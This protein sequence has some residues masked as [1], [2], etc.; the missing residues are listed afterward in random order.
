[1]Q[2]GSFTYLGHPLAHP[3]AKQ[4]S[5]DLLTQSFKQ[6]TAM[7]DRL[8]L[9]CF[10]RVTIVNKV[11]LPRWVYR[12][13]FLLDLTTC[14][15]WDSY[16]RQFVTACPGIESVM[17]RNRLGTD[18]RLGGLGLRT[19]WWSFALRWVS[20]VQPMLQDHRIP[21][22]LPLPHPHLTYLQILSALGVKPG[23][24]T[25]PT[26]KPRH[27]T[28]LIDSESSG[29]EAWILRLPPTSSH[30]S[31][32]WFSEPAHPTKQEQVSVQTLLP[33]KMTIMGVEVQYAGVPTECTWYTD[34]S[35]SCG[36]AGGG[37]V[38]GSFQAAFRVPGMQEVYRAEVVA[39]A[40][41]CALAKVADTIKLDNRACATCIA[42]QRTREVPD[43]DFRDL[44]CQE[45]SQKNLTILWTPGHVSLNDTQTYTA[46]KDARENGRADSCARLGT[47][48]PHNPPLLCNPWDIILHGTKL[49]TPPRAWLMKMRSQKV[50]TNTHW[51]TWLPL[52]GMRRSTWLPWLWGHVRWQDYGAPWEKQASPCNLCTLN[53]GA[54]VQSRL[55]YCGRWRRHFYDEWVKWWGPL[56]A[57]ATVWLTSADE[58]DLWMCACLHIP[59]TLLES[60]PIHEKRH[61]RKHVAFFQF[62]AIHGVQ[63]LRNILTGVSPVAQPSSLWLSTK[64]AARPAVPSSSTP[65]ARQLRDYVHA[66]WGIKPRRKEPTVLPTT[67]VQAE[68]TA[69]IEQAT[70]AKDTDGV[71]FI[72]NRTTTVSYLRSKAQSSYNE[73]SQAHYDIM[74]AFCQEKTSLWEA[75]QHSICLRSKLTSLQLVLR[76][77]LHHLYTA[78]H[79]WFNQAMCTLLLS[80]DQVR[81]SMGTFW[82][83]RQQDTSRFCEWKHGECDAQMRRLQRQ[84][85]ALSLRQSIWDSLLRFTTECETVATGMKQ[86]LL[87]ATMERLSVRQKMWVAWRKRLR[88]TQDE[89]VTSQPRHKKPKLSHSEP[90]TAICLTHP[91]SIA[92]DQGTIWLCGEGSW[93]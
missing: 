3:S 34:G 72:L 6:D 93:E 52:K 61:I 26:R 69:W 66:P 15:T 67:T 22:I 20:I 36:R 41:A 51:T 86:N 46:Y 81:S 68:I 90:E 91:D 40:L 17:S 37:I 31:F 70:A 89:E 48:L 1:M 19:L 9:N 60:I 14:Q 54:S 13:L 47:L 73:L 76:E 53:H 71:T 27:S 55:L 44:A 12:A 50:L 56:A 62:R 57:Q 39:C 11:L 16:L 79:D 83:Q 59:T 28:S 78:K 18:V 24:T 4:H 33:Q 63:G 10:E 92:D 75:A 65:T 49:P 29:D 35:K 5:L 43:Q 87:D 42:Q 25:L 58:T 84:L 38:N 74:D 21:A 2:Q 30:V 88:N 77:Q 82:A 32:D 7:Y 23:A 45:I 8:P 80:W 64:P 85:Y